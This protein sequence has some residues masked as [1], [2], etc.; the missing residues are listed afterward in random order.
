MDILKLDTLDLPLRHA[1]TITRGSRTNASNLLLTLQRGEFIGYGE[2]A[3]NKRYDETPDTVRKAIARF[4]PTTIVNPWDLSMVQRQLKEQFPHEGAVRA[5]LEMAYADLY[6]KYL[7]LPLHR[8]WNAP[9]EVGPRTSFTIGIDSEE[10]IRQ[11]IEEAKPYAIL[12]VK[13]GTRDDREVMRLIRSLTTKEIWIDANEG[14]TDPDEAVDLARY[15]HR[16]NVRLIEQPMPAA[17]ADELAM[18][19]LASPL[20]IIAD[21]GF[22]GAEDMAHIARCYHGIN[23]KLMKTGGMIPALHYL[24][25]ARKHGLKVM[26]GC[27]LESSLANTA[28][29]I[30]GLWADYCDLDSHLLISAD[31]FS[32]LNVGEDSRVYLNDKPGLGVVPKM[33]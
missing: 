13:L 33:G 25:E 28:A 26:V 19:K 6:G 10:M 12:K 15:M 21:E 17:M 8:L 27:M 23:L 14:W 4:D 2:C 30:V 9:S 11:K 3:P 5:G 32:G 20:P 22:T 7:G 29:A 24:W 1:F 16:M 18:L 31:P